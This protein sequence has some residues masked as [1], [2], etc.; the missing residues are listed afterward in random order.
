MP[1]EQTDL[2]QMNPKQSQ[3]ST[4]TTMP[5]VQQQMPGVAGTSN[6]LPHS[7]TWNPQQYPQVAGF[8]SLQSLDMQNQNQVYPYYPLS[9]VLP[10]AVS[11]PFGLSSPVMVSP[12][13]TLQ[14]QQVGQ[15]QA[16][17]TSADVA[18]QLNKTLD[19]VNI[20]LDREQAYLVQP[21]IDSISVGPSTTIRTSSKLSG[22]TS[23][24]SA[25]FRNYC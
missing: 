1:G 2:I 7:H 10:S 4:A 20:S 8:P 9:S 18:L 25:H 23:S 6:T 14:L 24:R 21:T 11:L 5:S 19:Q 13:A 16:S 12:Y 3:Q 22:S 15:A 17:P